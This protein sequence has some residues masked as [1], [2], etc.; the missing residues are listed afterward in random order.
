M[1]CNYLRGRPFVKNILYIYLICLCAFFTNRLK[2]YRK[3][4]YYLLKIVLRNKF[5]WYNS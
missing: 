4:K 5:F 3:Q 1:S 2:I